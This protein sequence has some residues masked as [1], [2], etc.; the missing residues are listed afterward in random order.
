MTFMFNT[1]SSKVFPSQ[2][3][4]FLNVLLFYI[5]PRAFECLC[6]TKESE[7]LYSFIAVGFFV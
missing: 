1:I 7:T 6:F 5:F 4:Y 2:R 3:I